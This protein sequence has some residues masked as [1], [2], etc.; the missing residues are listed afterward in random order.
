MA[1]KALRQHPSFLCTSPAYL[2]I[3]PSN[4]KFELEFVPVQV[5]ANEHHPDCMGQPPPDP[6]RDP[7]DWSPFCFALHRYLNSSEEERNGMLKLIPHVADG[8]WVLKQAVGTTPVVLGKKLKT[9]YHATHKYLEVRDK[10]I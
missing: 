5:Y 10:Y 7:Q 1:T 4:S 3:S 9:V 2:C 8:S 6:A